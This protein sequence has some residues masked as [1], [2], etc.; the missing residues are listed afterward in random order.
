MIGMIRERERIAKISINNPF[1]KPLTEALDKL[2]EIKGYMCFLL[3]KKHFECNFK[4]GNINNFEYD[5]LCLLIDEYEEISV[6][7]FLNMYGYELTE[8]NI[9]Y[10]EEFDNLIVSDSLFT[11]FLV[12]KGYKLK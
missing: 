10:L 4:Q 2:K 12:Y 5:L 3:D 9:E 8:T 11:C 6:G 1:L 7:N